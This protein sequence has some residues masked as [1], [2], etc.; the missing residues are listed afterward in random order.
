MADAVVVTREFDAPRELVFRAWTEREHLLRWFAP[1]TFTTPYC[2]V[3][4][5][6]GGMFHYCMRTPEGQ[7]IW[8]RGVYREIVAPERLVFVDSFADE[9]GNAAE[10]ARYG[11]SAD[12]PFE[13]LVTV[14]F[15]ERDGKTLVTVR[16]E[17]PESV[18]ER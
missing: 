4:L 10:P 18:P 11:T 14:T 17:V 16:Q 6:V 1:K 15:E 2:S 13:T 3:D 8:G 5:R 7:D 12:Y 9:Q